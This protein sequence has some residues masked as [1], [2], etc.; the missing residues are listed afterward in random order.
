MS[1][2]SEIYQTQNESSY[3][4]VLQ[5]V[6]SLVYRLPWICGRYIFFSWWELENQEKTICYHWWASSEPVLPA[7]VDAHRAKWQKC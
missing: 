6:S 5:V 4:V 1:V 7:S 2:M 3:Q